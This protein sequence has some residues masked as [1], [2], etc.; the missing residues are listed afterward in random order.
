[1]PVT[2][3]QQEPAAVTRRIDAETLSLTAEMWSQINT[4]QYL[5]DLTAG[6]SAQKPRLLVGGPGRD[7]AALA[8]E[9]WVRA[10]S[11]AQVQSKS[12]LNPSKHFQHCYFQ[13]SHFLSIVTLVFYLVYALFLQVYFMNEYYTATCIK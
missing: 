12:A 5:T 3:E 4:V 7:A 8:R 2:L 13:T 10:P 11:S 1:M 9:H 6:S